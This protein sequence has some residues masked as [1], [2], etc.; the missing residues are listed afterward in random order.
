M[1]YLAY[2]IESTTL[3]CLELFQLIVPHVEHKYEL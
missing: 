1:M 2:V 3:S